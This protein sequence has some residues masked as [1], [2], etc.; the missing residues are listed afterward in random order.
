MAT[1]LRNP[2]AAGKPI[3]KKR[4]PPKGPIRHGPLGGQGAT[5]DG[6]PARLLTHGGETSILLVL[7]SLL[8]RAVNNKVPCRA[9]NRNIRSIKTAPGPHPALQH[10]Q[11]NNGRS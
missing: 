3:P 7:F 11:A 10:S 2:A 9:R 6:P 5:P 1:S 4:T 8:L